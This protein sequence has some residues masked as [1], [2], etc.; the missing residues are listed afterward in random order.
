MD[1]RLGERAMA[2]ILTSAME[3]N[4]R[5][6]AAWSRS[7]LRGYV[8][9]IKAMPRSNAARDGGTIGNV[10]PLLHRHPAPIRALR[11]EFARRDFFESV[12]PELIH[13]KSNGRSRW[14]TCRRRTR[15][16][17]VVQTVFSRHPQ[18]AAPIYG[19]EVCAATIVEAALTDRREKV[20]GAWTRSWSRASGLPQGSATTF[21][22]IDGFDR[23]LERDRRVNLVEAADHDRDFGERGRFSDRTKRFWTPSFIAT[24][25]HVRR[26]AAATRAERPASHVG[27]ANC[28]RGERPQR[29]DWASAGPGNH[30]ARHQSDNRRITDSNE[31]GPMSSTSVDIIDLLA[32]DHA[33]LEQLLAELNETPAIERGSGFRELVRTIVVHEAA[34]EMVV[35]PAVRADAPD[36]DI[37]ADERIEEQA[38]AEQMLLK[39]SRIDPA[40][41]EFTVW[42]AQLGDA[43]L[44]HARAEERDIFPMLGA[45]K[46]KLAREELGV[47]YRQAKERAPSRPHPHLPDTPPGN[48]VLGSIAAVIDAGR[49][50]MRAALTGSAGR[51]DPHV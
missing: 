3:T 17:R 13:E 30:N 39:M 29:P 28:P 16:I 36:G 50:A 47:L 11:F 26:A 5:T 14:S 2:T 43:V 42:L 19:P 41:P 51:E 6:F 40:S 18:S 22:A 25:P 48:E 24:L 27:S 7:T 31:G 21:A 8:W 33:L 9:G 49:D 10:S 4:P 37:L 38:A 46:N 44:A 15:L 20:P 12:R 45:A 23:P 32:A 35:Y 34:E 1:R